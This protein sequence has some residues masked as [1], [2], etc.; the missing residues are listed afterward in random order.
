MNSN[1]YNRKGY[2]NFLAFPK[3]EEISNFW[4]F[5][6]L[7]KYN[8]CFTSYGLKIIMSTTTIHGHLDKSKDLYIG[9]SKNNE[10]WGYGYLKVLVFRFFLKRKSLK[11]AYFYGFGKIYKF[12]SI[13]YIA[14]PIWKGRGEIVPSED[15]LWGL[16]NLKG[17]V[18]DLAKIYVRTVESD[19]KDLSK[20]HI[21]IGRT[22]Y[23]VLKRFYLSEGSNRKA[24]NGLILS[25]LK[26][27]FEKRKMSVKLSN[28]L[29]LFAI[30]YPVE[31]T[32]VSLNYDKYTDYNMYL[33]NQTLNIIESIYMVTDFPRSFI[34]N[35]LIL[36]GV[37]NYNDFMREVENKFPGYGLKK[38]RRISDKLISMCE[39]KF[40]EYD[41]YFDISYDAREK[42]LKSYFCYN[43]DE[44]KETDP[45]LYKAGVEIWGDCNEKSD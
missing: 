41:R 33:Y 16:D 2:I 20:L 40:G 30:D 1:M 22:E 4:Q 15:L 31:V 10:I 6:N 24:Y 12:F 36:G 26:R 39:K 27:F 29:I 37:K 38:G 45:E 17:D 14:F 19:I 25:G 11:R 34:V 18:V 7:I 5:G 32:K 21:T 43:K 42:F 44:L 8:P 23:Y 9:F 35:Y 28:F 13:I 3:M